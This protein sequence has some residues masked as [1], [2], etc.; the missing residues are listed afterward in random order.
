M[1][2][3]KKLTGKKNSFQYVTGITILTCLIF[4]LLGVLVYSIENHNYETDK[5][6]EL[7]AIADQKV[8]MITIWKKERLADASVISQDYGFGATVR[9]YVTNPDQVDEKYLKNRLNSLVDEYGYIQ[10][11]ILAQDQKVIL[12][13]EGIDYPHGSA[14]TIPLESTLVVNR[15]VLTDFYVVEEMDLVLISIVASI[16]DENRQPV[17]FIHFQIDPSKVLFTSLQSWPIPSTTAET[18]LV[19]RVGERVVFISQTRYLPTAP[20]SR[21]FS[22]ELTDIPAVQAALGK[23][24]HT[25]GV[26]YRG[27]PVVAYLT[28]IPGTGW[29]IV[30]KIDKAEVF[31]ELYRETGLLTGVILLLNLFVISFGINISHTRQSNLYKRLYQTQKD[32]TLVREFFRATLYSMGDGVII[33]DTSGLITQMNP[34]AEKLTGWMENE[35]IGIPLHT[36]FSIMNGE[37]RLPVDDPARIVMT[38]GVAGSLCEKTIL[39]ARN[40]TEY[41]IVE[42]GAPIHIAGQ[43]DGI[44][45]V[46]RDMSTEYGLQEMM[47]S[48]NER[49]QLLFDHL[50][51]GFALFELQQTD[52]GLPSDLLLID[53]NL[54]FERIL[55][56]TVPALQGKSIT[57]LFGFTDSFWVKT[58]GS[59]AITQKPA[60][61]E[62]RLDSTG[63][64]YEFLTY[65]PTGGQ[66]ALLLN[67]ITARKQAEDAIRTSEM[68]YRNRSRELE[69]LYTLS[70]SLREAQTEDEIYTLI[71]H[72]LNTIIT[73]DSAEVIISD[74]ITDRFTIVQASGF[75]QNSRGISFSA[76]E[77]VTSDIVASRESLMI[78]DYGSHPKAFFQDPAAREIGPALFVPMQDKNDL[79][80]VLVV[81]RRKGK[82]TTDFAESELRLLG[83]ISE[84]AG[85][86]L[87]RVRMSKKAAAQLRRTQ[88]L[89]AIDSTISG[90]FDLQHVLQAILSTACTELKVDAAAIALL[91]QETMIL[92]YKAICGFTLPGRDLPHIRLQKSLAAESV[93][94]Q[95]TSHLIDIVE[96]P[97][98]LEQNPLLQKNQFADYYATPII[99]KGKIL[100]VLEVFHRQ[101]VS[102]DQDWFDYYETLAGQASLAIDNL[103]LFESIQSNNH[104]LRITY[105]HTLEGWSG[106]MDLHC[107]DLEGSSVALAECAIAI[108]RRM[109]ISG[110]ELIDLR[111][112]ALLHDIG[113]MGLPAALLQ[114]PAALT[115]AERQ[116][117][118]SHPRLGFQ[119]V[120]R[121]DYLQDAANIIHAH[122]ERWDGSGYPD[123][124]RQSA[125]PTGAAILAVADVWLALASNR[126]WRPRWEPERIVEYL[127]QNRGI[128]FD[129]LVVD[130]CISLLQ[131]NPEYFQTG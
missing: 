48:Q 86:A 109:N 49:Y 72:Q 18:L 125:I 79:I 98:L 70:S 130:Q 110:K 126:P 123:H 45:L 87:H 29:I 112:A 6:N 2:I 93:I 21:S 76:S 15:P 94:H 73:C 54:A 40:G 41:P 89:H 16:Q 58:I 115:S 68:N 102:P 39:I 118:E 96:K 53:A 31:A 114:K 52:Q 42:S 47:H 65:A 46:F 30:S 10:V 90:S 106:S 84:L 32:E 85:S 19:K 122:H 78:T 88:S 60:S 7:K 104:Q 111:R 74:P 71:M 37:T 26:D 61:F 81:T 20:L 11:A 95:Q 63:S 44:V 128:L 92:D 4:L 34:V 82:N 83:A 50:Q 3:F 120:N 62:Y 5:Y 100:G 13:S 24:G 121:I 17:G 77:G 103:T 129:P 59:V 38:A 91:N 14:L 1:D 12:K 27:E 23:T 97:E 55:G 51:Q 33:T 43:I 69:L 101:K 131:E 22:L 28:T 119:I 124:L 127:L 108:A 25:E 64:T 75:L 66:V 80:G 99:A 107:G 67:D 57:E 9:R 35:A 36:V 113:E 116:L 105:D 117:L 8:Q 56:L